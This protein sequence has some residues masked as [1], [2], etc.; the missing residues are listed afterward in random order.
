MQA[1]L[2]PLGIVAA[3]MIS[4]AIHRVAVPRTGE[5]AGWTIGAL[6]GFPVGGIVLLAAFGNRYHSAGILFLGS[7][8]GLIAGAIVGP[9]LGAMSLVR[10]G[11]R[12]DGVNPSAN[13]S[14]IIPLI[15]VVVFAAGIL[16][17]SHLLCR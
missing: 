9:I 5:A 8:G 13:T 3:L 10:N 6:V 12:G 4:R 17:V 7:V 15:P 1:V 16:T 11:D 2:I 14:W